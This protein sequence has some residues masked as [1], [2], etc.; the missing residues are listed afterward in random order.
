[1][2]DACINFLITF[3]L[4]VALHHDFNNEP[5]HFPIKFNH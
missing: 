5:P 4:V 1:M 2:P 3:K